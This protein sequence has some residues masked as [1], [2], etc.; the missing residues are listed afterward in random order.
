MSMDWA[1]GLSCHTSATCPRDWEVCLSCLG[2]SFFQSP[3]GLRFGAPAGEPVFA[4]L[5][6]GE[7][8]I[9]L[10]AGVWRQYPLSRSPRHFYSPTL[11]ALSDSSLQPAAIVARTEYLPGAGAAEVII[12][13]YDSCW[14][15]ET[16]PNGARLRREYVLSLKRGA[17]QIAAPFSE[18]HRDH[19]R[20]GDRERWV[21][22]MPEGHE[23]LNVLRRGTATRYGRPCLSAGLTTAP[24]I[25]AV[26]RHPKGIGAAPQSGCVGGSWAC[27]QR[28]DARSTIAG[29]PPPRRFSRRIRPMDCSASRTG[30]GRRRNCVA[31]RTGRCARATSAHIGL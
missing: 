4:A 10:A 15:A 9:G 25:S 1:R 23:A 30:L 11:P 14:G 28:M 6:Q 26:G 12:D 29:V 19:L 24:T 21:L 17:D 13:S 16:L 7:T 5:H 8:V 18:T 20:R 22:R 2:G 31:A 27:S 3:P